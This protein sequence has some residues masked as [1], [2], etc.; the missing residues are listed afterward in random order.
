M[1]LFKIWIW[2]LLLN[3]SSQAQHWFRPFD[4]YKSGIFAL[5]IQGC[6]RIFLPGSQRNTSSHCSTL[7]WTRYNN[8]TFPLELVLDESQL[9]RCGQTWFGQ[10]LDYKFHC[11]N[12]RSNL[13]FA[14]CGGPQE[15]WKAM[16]L[17]W[18][19]KIKC[20]QKNISIS[21]TIYRG[22]LGYGS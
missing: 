4:N 3:C 1:S 22:G 16:H 11:S 15:K 7:D 5:R 12:G 6:L 21:S 2:A 10:T 13:A 9:C 20:N 14:H 8:T 19:Q 17:R 18:F